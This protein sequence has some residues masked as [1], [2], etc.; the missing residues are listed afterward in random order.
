[1][2]KAKK[3]IVSTVVVITT[4]FISN[5]QASE[6]ISSLYEKALISF[7]NN[8][9]STSVIHLKNLLK[10]DP[11]NISARVL[12]AEAY[13]FQGL[14]IAAEE[15]L[16]FAKLAN[17]DM[18]RLVTLFA[19]AYLLQHK[20][21]EALEVIKPG[22]RGKI[23]ESELFVLKGQALLGKK[24][25]KSAGVAFKEALTLNKN[26]KL[27]HLGEAQV[28]FI[29]GLFEKSLSSIENILE[30][31][32]SFVNA[33]IFKAKILQNISQTEQ[34]ILAIEKAISIEPKHLD[35]RLTFAKL[36]VSTKNYKDAEAQVD[37]ILSEIPEEPRAGYLKAIINASINKGDPNK[38]L[39]EVITTLNAVPDEV[40]QT[41]PDY[42][43]LAGLTNFQFGNRE[44]ARRYLNKYLTFTE[45]HIPSVRMLATIDLED[46]NLSSA[47]NLLSKTNIANPD[48]PNI[49]T[50]LGL[51]YLQLE[52][53]KKA[54]FFFEKVLDMYPTS[55]VGI[56][57]MAKS[58]ISSGEY[59][60]AIDALI[61]I[62]DNN[63]NGVQIKLLLIDTYEK[64]NMVEKAINIAEQLIVQFPENIYFYQRLSSLLAKE[65]DFE[66]AINYLKKAIALDENNLGVFI[67]LG[68]LYS[69]KGDYELAKSILDQ[70][71]I[72]FPDNPSVIVA[73]ADVALFQ[74]DLPQALS[75]SQKAYALTPDNFNV[76]NQY[77]KILV[78]NGETQ[79]AIEV[80][81]LFIGV[82]SKH[83][84]A[85]TLMAE[86]Y[87]MVNQHE[88]AIILYRELVKLSNNKVSALIT[89][90]KA[91][92]SASYKLDAIKSFQKAIINDSQ[93][94]KAHLGLAKLLVEQ[95]NEKYAVSIIN[96]LYNLTK[97]IS[98]REV[99]LGDLYLN[100]NN[101]NQAISHYKSA[102]KESEQKQA[103]IGL[104]QANKRNNSVKLVIPALEKW[105]KKHPNDFIVSVALADSF[106]ANKQ[107]DEALSLYL[108]L[109][110]QYKNQPILFNNL[111]NLYFDM[112]EHEQALSYANK[113]YELID[114]NVAIIDTLA[115]I[116]SRLGNN[117]RALSLFRIALLKDFDNA[118]IK[119]HLAVTL[120]QVERQKEAIGYLTE[121]IASDKVF[122]EREQAR[123]LLKTLQG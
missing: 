35:A 3:L 104:Y 17:V 79:K 62:K 27:A 12:L 123:Q 109:N 59:T 22:K 92:I 118:Q 86:L 87:Q 96:A 120:L 44:D 108:N 75:L 47:Q 24:L 102:L 57:N 51:T 101:N 54:E 71:L 32:A 64:T 46:G 70:K 117:E 116:E 78:A 107:Y 9:V 25:F 31:D 21:D 88:Q 77:I 39:I 30:I 122:Q 11:D 58:K 28:F 19:K 38:K 111:A 97:S 56:A 91:Q 74:K 113:A 94:V 65:N 61:A 13:I 83:K 63:I 37:F 36:L 23:I 48:N 6:N 106:K 81:D 52:N 60:S 84:L 26:N 45:F 41:T 103:L 10:K 73:L 50:L 14:A 114:D 82:N 33:W 49:L 72:E 40:M 42:Y 119:Y 112:G 98:L 5:L 53:N 1:M 16:K 8:E 105:L 18:D 43:Y 7:N 69:V 95:A 29:D 76:V 2:F 68:R 115:W 100:L 99:L 67:Q 89:L 85:L 15:E 93:S 55:E 80:V 66:Q 20:Y 90:A 4:L 34:A 121:V 110:Q